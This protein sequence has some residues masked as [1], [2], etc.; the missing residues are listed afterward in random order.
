M[1]RQRA[2]VPEPQ[3]ARHA[4]GD[5]GRGRRQLAEDL[6]LVAVLDDQHAV[7][8]LRVALG[9]PLAQRVVDEGDPRGAPE[10]AALPPPGGVVVGV[11]RGVLEEVERPGVAV[12]DDI[13]D[14]G[15]PVRR[16]GRREHA[17]GVAR[18]QHQVDRR[19]PVQLADPPDHRR[20]PRRVAL[21]ED[22]GLQPAGQA[23]RHARQVG[24]Q[25]REAADVRLPGLRREPDPVDGHVAP[26]RR[27]EAGVIGVDVVGEELALRRDHRHVPAGRREVIGGRP[28]AVH[29]ARPGRREVERDVDEAR[30]GGLPGGRGRRPAGGHRPRIVVLVGSRPQ[31][32]DVAAPGGAGPADRPA[33]PSSDR[34]ARP[35]VSG[36]YRSERP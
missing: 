30:A 23:L 2:H 10:D 33:D 6:G 19:A 4:A 1:L 28:A 29:A 13:G 17:E 18:G 21:G 34:R 15:E 25:P 7:G 5:H 24:P 35:T 36:S 9:V 22:G 3:R 11:R 20:D 31:A 8:L 27:L 26:D 12:V 16:P 32:R 14:A